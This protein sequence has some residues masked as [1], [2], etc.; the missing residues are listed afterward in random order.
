MRPVAA[1]AIQLNPRDGEVVLRGV[2]FPV[3]MRHPGFDPDVLETW[4]AI[5]GRLE[6]VGG[7]L[8]YMPPCADTQQYVAV[9]VVHV[10][11]T[12]SEAHPEFVIGSNEAGMKLGGDIRG[13]DAAVWRRVDVGVPKGHFQLVAPVLA[14]E[15]AGEDEGEQDLLPKAKWYLDKGARVVWIVLPETR[16]VVVVTATGSTTHGAGASLPEAPDLPGLLPPVAS[17]FSQLSA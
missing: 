15:I 7:K 17:F 10:L 2:R 16:E 9:D 11:R 12:W 4:P 6:Y 8:L 5:V 1:V 14:V 3:E 13:A